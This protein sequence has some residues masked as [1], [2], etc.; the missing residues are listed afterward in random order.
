MATSLPV[1][2]SFKSK[3]PFVPG[4]IFPSATLLALFIVVIKLN[5]FDPSSESFTLK[6]HFATVA[7]PFSVSVIL[8]FE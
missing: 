8:Y 2:S 4:A 6:L 7:V 3:Y 1:P 5:V